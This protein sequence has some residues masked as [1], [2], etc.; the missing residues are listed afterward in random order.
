MENQQP[1]SKAAELVEKLKAASKPDRELD[2][3]FCSLFGYEVRE[4][5]N[6]YYYEPI[7]DYSW[8]LVPNYSGSVDEILKIFEEKAVF[9]KEFSLHELFHD[10]LNSMNFQYHWA[11]RF[12]LMEERN[13]LPINLMLSFLSHQRQYSSKEHLE[14]VQKLWKSTAKELGLSETDGSNNEV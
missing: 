11:T 12:S 10:A 2:A 14:E 6:R 4:H 9:N 5:G 3:A 1:K 8:Q 13:T 7:P